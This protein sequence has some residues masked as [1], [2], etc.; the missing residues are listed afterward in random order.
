MSRR[1]TRDART[2]STRSATASAEDA[3]TVTVCRGCCCGSR[4]KHP[5]LDHDAQLERVRAGV[6][7]AARVRVSDCLDA[8]ERSNVMV[9]TPSASGRRAGGR[10][11]WLGGVLDDETTD[12][13]AGRAGSG[14]PGASEPPNVRDLYA[15][16]PSSRVRRANTR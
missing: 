6:G 15:F 8:C 3:V 16:T 10:P 14:G 11:V 5:E 9:L 4:S 12:D 2:T 13:V 1:R 7:P